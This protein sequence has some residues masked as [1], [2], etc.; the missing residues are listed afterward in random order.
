MRAICALGD[1]SNWATESFTTLPVPCP[2]PI[3]INHLQA[4][5]TPTEGTLFW[6]PQREISNPESRYIVQYKADTTLLWEN[7]TEITVQDTFKHFTALL[8]STNYNVRVSAICNAGDESDWIEHQFTTNATELII[9]DG[10]TSN[11]QLPFNGIML[12][13]AQHNQLIYPFDMLS[14]LNGKTITKLTF[15]LNNYSAEVENWTSPLTIK[16]KTSYFSSLESGFQSVQNSTTV[17]DGESIISWY[18]EEEGT[19]EIPLT[20][21][22]LYDGAN[23]LLD[24]TTATGDINYASFLGTEAPFTGRYSDDDEEEVL[25]FLP[26]IKID[27][28]LTPETFCWAVSNMETL[29]LQPFSTHIIWEAGDNNNSWLVQY[30]TLE[31]ATWSNTVEASAPALFIDQ[32]LEN[33]TYQVRVR[34]ACANLDDLSGWQTLAFTTPVRPCS[35]IDAVMHSEIL[36]TEATMTWNMVDHNNIQGNFFVQHK[37]STEDTWSTP[38]SVQDTIFTITNLWPLTTYDFRVQLICDNSQQSSLVSTTFSTLPVPCPTIEEISAVSESITYSEAT[39][40]WGTNEDPYS[41]I[42]HYTLQYKLADVTNWD[43]AS[44]ITHDELSATMFNMSNLTAA[45]AYQVRVRVNCIS[46]NSDWEEISFTTK[47]A[48]CPEPTNLSFESETATPFQ[49]TLTWDA[50]STPSNWNS[51]FIF[52]YKL[53]TTPSWGGEDEVTISNLLE[54]SVTITHLLPATVYD[55]RVKAI[56]SVGDTSEWITSE[57]TTLSNTVVVADAATAATSLLPVN[58]SFLFEAQHNQMI[59]TEN[60]LGDLEGKLLTKLTFFMTSP[61]SN[62]IVWTSSVDV[63]LGTTTDASLSNGLSST[64]A[65]FTV[66]YT[67]HLRNWADGALL[68]IELDNPYL[69][70]GGNLLV[71]FS[72][73]AGGV[74]AATFSGIIKEAAGRFTS[75]STNELLGFLPKLMFTYEP[76]PEEYCAPVTY[77]TSNNITPFAAHLT[78]DIHE[79]NTSWVAQYKTVEEAVWSNEAMLTLPQISLAGLTENTQYEV[80]VRALCSE[81]VENDESVWMTH[82]F[83]TLSVPCPEVTA[84]HHQNGTLA[85][86]SVTLTWELED[87]PHSWNESYTLQYKTTG[88]SNW[89][90]IDEIEADSYVLTALTPATQ[91]QARVQSICID[92]AT[93]DWVTYN[94][95]TATPECISP[96]N[97][98]HVGESL[99]PTSATVTWEAGADPYQWNQGYVLEYKVAEASWDDLSTVTVNDLT[100]TTYPLTSLVPQTTYDVRVQSICNNEQVSEWITHS[101]TTL[102]PPCEPANNVVAVAEDPYTISLSWEGEADN[103]L[104]RYRT[105][106]STQWDTVTSSTSPASIEELTPETTYLIQIQSDCSIT[107]SAWIP[108]PAITITTLTVTY[109]ITATAHGAGTIHPE[110]VMEYEEGSTPLYTFIPEAGGIV[111]RI[112]VSGE[113]IPVGGTQYMF[114]PLTE[115]QT[116]DVYFSAVGIDENE[117]T[118]LINLYPNPAQSSIT[119]ESDQDVITKIEILDMT[120]R[121]VMR[122]QS[123]EFTNLN[124]SHLENGVYFVRVTTTTGMTTLRF[125]KQ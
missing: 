70:E 5:I 88:S 2:T 59:Y 93:T 33:T 111:A 18:N 83:T 85:E 69:Y 68:E 64:D 117:S 106:S 66:A 76:S 73:S 50:S 124:I 35:E 20:Y 112:E 42:E 54:P 81:Y 7:G 13:E 49:A 12:N 46:N 79:S 90:T 95:S 118:P 91:Y 53:G 28:T 92:G 17:I 30:K 37:A 86:T 36:T 110:G 43:D 120:G 97:L 44:V 100:T 115:N 116:I 40:E 65:S 105:Q 108:E 38:E 25:S 114:P 74:S 125:I 63:K 62:D 26:K 61:P 80:R 87:D 109:T 22:F 24:I 104:I 16:M 8:P 41:W 58:T 29:N 55:M 72:T 57:F 19:I 45:T 123:N 82:S 96:S 107:T 4:S 3:A 52:E 6:T 32:L 71:D 98:T 27:Y 67:A 89:T 15:Y 11:N 77:I 31:E 34:A 75:G 51:E 23:L 56:C 122:P 78:W 101:F 102:V 113:E 84:L 9:A 121:M 21:P 47:P 103:Y 39:I 10:N 14:E 48:P 119:I 1:T 60:M 99:T 94:F